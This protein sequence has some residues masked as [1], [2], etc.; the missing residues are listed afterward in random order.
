[1]GGVGSLDLAVPSFPYRTPFPTSSRPPLGSIKF[2]L[3][4][5]SCY[6]NWEGKEAGSN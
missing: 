5:P 6:G 1:M 2:W 3:L 4:Q